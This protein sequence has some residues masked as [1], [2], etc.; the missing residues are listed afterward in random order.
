MWL[1]IGL[2]RKIG[3]LKRGKQR[4]D[5][6]DFT[7]DVSECESVSRQAE[8]GCLNTNYITPSMTNFWVHQGPTCAIAAVTELAT[9]ELER[10]GSKLGCELGPRS[11][12]MT[13][14]HCWICWIDCEYFGIWN[15][16]MSYSGLPFCV[17]DPAKNSFFLCIQGPTYEPANCSWNVF[18]SVWVLKFRNIGKTDDAN[19][20][21]C[22]SWVPISQGEEWKDLREIAEPWTSLGW[23]SKSKERSQSSDLSRAPR[24]VDGLY[25]C[26]CAGK[27]AYGRE[28]CSAIPLWTSSDG[29]CLKSTGSS[30]PPYLK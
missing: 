16:V 8:I 10:Q 28:S 27:S 11:P 7:F 9:Q 6:L 29:F 15:K 13:G 1:F 20:G 14:I 12:N 3:E 22:L 30:L 26:R 23:S 17:S 21:S 19:L 24:F 2:W 4:K 18:F 5:Q 25:Q